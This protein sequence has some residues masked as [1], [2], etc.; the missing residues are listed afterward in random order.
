LQE[1]GV[2]GQNATM[3]FI[4]CE[5]ATSDSLLEEQRETCAGNVQMQPHQKW[6]SQWG[7]LSVVCRQDFVDS[8]NLPHGSSADPPTDVGDRQACSKRM[9]LWWSLWSVVLA[10]FALFIALQVTFLL[11]LTTPS[12]LVHSRNLTTLLLRLYH[13]IHLLL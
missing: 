13:L 6:K 10:V 4:K 7:E 2:V 11:G 3:I 9:V 12:P 1:E 5:C 8:A